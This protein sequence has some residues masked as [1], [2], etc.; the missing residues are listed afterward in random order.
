[1]DGMLIIHLI[2]KQLYVSLNMFIMIHNPLI[3][4][5]INLKILTI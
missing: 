4:I 2:K 1:M 3:V 5:K